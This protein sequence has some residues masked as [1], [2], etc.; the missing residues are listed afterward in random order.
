MTRERAGL[1]FPASKHWE[2]EPCS[3]HGSNTFAKM[4]AASGPE[5][6]CSIQNPCDTSTTMEAGKG[7]PAGLSVTL[8]VEPGAAELFQSCPPS[9]GAWAGSSP[10]PQCSALLSLH[11]SALGSTHSTVRALQ[12]GKPLLTSP[13]PQPAP[14]APLGEHC[15]HL[16][17]GDH[18]IDTSTS[19]RSPKHPNVATSWVLESLTPAPGSKPLLWK[20]RLRKKAVWKGQTP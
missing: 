11:S 1:S 10:I 9:R 2:H 4:R 5:P 17:T 16:G 13:P 7:E 3:A 8:K 12:T 15:S 20:T 6:S 14:L 18:S 19:A